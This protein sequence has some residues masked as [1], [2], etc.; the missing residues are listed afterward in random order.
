MNVNFYG[1]LNNAEG[2]LTPDMGQFSAQFAPIDDSSQVLKTI[3][4]FVSLGAGLALGPIWTNGKACHIV[5]VKL[6]FNCSSIVMLKM[7]AA[8]KDS[9][10][11]AAIKDTL[12]PIVIASTAI[13]K[14]NTAAYLY[15]T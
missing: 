6:Y 7:P 13:T 11:L 3:I 15:A 12:G 5:T 2:H 4:S 10:G 14:D 1:A 9:V 8:I